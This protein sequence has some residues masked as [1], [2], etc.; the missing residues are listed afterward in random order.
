MAE[1]IIFITEY[2]SSF[3]GN[4]LEIVDVIPYLKEDFEVKVL[5]KKEGNLTDT[6]LNSLGMDRLKR[7]SKKLLWGL[8]TKHTTFIVTQDYGIKLASLLK[9]LQY[10]N[11]RIICFLEKEPNQIKDF[12]FYL[13]DLFVTTS[14]FLKEEWAEV[15]I[16][17]RKIRVINKGVEM[18]S[19][20]KERQ[21][22]SFGF[23]GFLG[24][25]QGLEFL[26]SSTKF[27]K[28][29]LYLT[30]PRDY[31]F[32]IPPDP[33][34]KYL[35]KYSN[36]EDFYLDMDF[37]VYPQFLGEDLS[38]NILESLSYGVPVFCTDIGANQEIML[39][40]G[41]EDYMF[42]P[43]SISSFMDCFYNK[44]FESPDY[45]RKIVEKNFSLE[46]VMRELKNIL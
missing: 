36:L 10:F 39:K 44:S 5:F 4:S 31:N 46:K 43:N 18:P 1:Q 38:R 13:T 41:L 15:G 17:K 35:G 3:V 16:N 8:N 23:I 21:T 28:E 12:N 20:K 45:Y 26:F 6:Y 11:P 40:C 7:I 24:K 14:D 33:H 37:I 32:V 19:R 27:L 22:S 30:G 25:N 42:L 2:L 29:T 9:S 34:I